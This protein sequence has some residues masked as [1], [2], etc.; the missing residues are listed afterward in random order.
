M[1]EEHLPRHI[2][3]IPDGN[4]RWAR[5]RGLPTA[6]GHAKGVDVLGDVLEVLLNRGVCHISVWGSSVSNIQKRSKIELLGL[7]RVFED[8]AV[9][10]LDRLNRETKRPFQ[11]TLSGEWK[12][13]LPK[14]TV[15]SFERLIERSRHH[16]GRIINLLMAYDG[17]AEMLRAIETLVVEGKTPVTPE[18]V[19]AALYTCDMPEVDLVVRTGCGSDPHWSDGFMM[20]DV[21]NAQMFFSSDTWPDFGI[22]GMN[23]ALESFSARERRLGA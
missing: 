12:E 8:A 16:R 17:R 23:E 15:S 11:V 21:A 2:A 6:A 13:H 19:K 14:S 5:S 18:M 7:F 10:M 1:Q 4:R 9:R 22:E 20:W 3:I